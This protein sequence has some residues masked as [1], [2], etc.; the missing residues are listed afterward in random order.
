VLSKFLF[1]F[2]TLLS[3]TFSSQ[4]E[5]KNEQIVNVELPGKWEVVSEEIK[6]DG[7]GHLR[8]IN[9]NGETITTEFVP[10]PKKNITAL[11]LMRDHRQ[12]ELKYKTPHSTWKL[13]EAKNVDDALFEWYVPQNSVY[14]TMYRLERF[15]IGSYG[16]HRIIYE[17][18]KDRSQDREM[19]IA[20][21]QNMEVNIGSY[22]RHSPKRHS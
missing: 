7:Y 18:N 8:V 5:Y 3:T 10:I 6:Q 17:T 13:I 16:Y 22:D 15:V 21:L 4:I 12:E 11:Q 1:G 14:D 2:I 19:W 9:K 20:T